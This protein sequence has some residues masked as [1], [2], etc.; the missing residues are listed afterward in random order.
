[1][2]ITTS[3]YLYLT[4]NINTNIIITKFMVKHGQRPIIITKH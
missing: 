4:V 3:T 2:I 1:M